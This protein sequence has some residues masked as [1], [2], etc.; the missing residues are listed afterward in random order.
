[1]QGGVERDVKLQLFFRFAR[2]ESEFLA[3]LVYCISFLSVQRKG[4]AI[5]LFM[6][7]RVCEVVGL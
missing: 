2:D 5:L 4:Y 1:M 7:V 3:D 6:Q